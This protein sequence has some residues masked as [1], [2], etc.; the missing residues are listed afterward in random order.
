MSEGVNLCRLAA[1]ERVCSRANYGIQNGFY[2]VRMRY[3]RPIRDA[4]LPINIKRIPVDC[5]VDLARGFRGAL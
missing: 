4:R 2:R 3:D 5:T 1:R